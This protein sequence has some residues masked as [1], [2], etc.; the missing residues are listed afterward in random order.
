MTKDL[1][2]GKNILKSHL[3][4]LKKAKEHSD[5][6]KRHLSFTTPASV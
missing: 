2:N 4:E 5:A 1:K 3:E 6:V